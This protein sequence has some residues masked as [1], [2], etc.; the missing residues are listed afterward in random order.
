LCRRVFEPA[1]CL[2]TGAAGVRAGKPIDKKRRTLVRA[3]RAQRSS[4]KPAP[5]W[6]N[7]GFGRSQPSHAGTTG[8][9]GIVAAQP[10]RLRKPRGSQNVKICSG[11]FSAGLGAAVSCRGLMIGSGGSTANR[12]AA[13]VI[14][15]W[16]DVGWAD[17]AVPG[18]VEWLEVADAGEVMGAVGR[19]SI[20]R[21]AAMLGDIV[22]IGA[23]GRGAIGRTG[24][25]VRGALSPIE[26]V[27]VP[28][29]SFTRVSTS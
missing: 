13:D 7:S 26:V 28:R 4:I 6:P 16:L 5:L 1:I 11:R 10:A 2:R 12:A 20:G 22:C 19:G 29:K 15:G 18:A 25:G 17:V 23:V 24:T 8:H 27:L 14:G 3:R 9:R 21:L